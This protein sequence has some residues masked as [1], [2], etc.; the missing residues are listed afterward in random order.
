[1]SVTSRI[2][3]DQAICADFDAE[4]ASPRAVMV[5]WP[6]LIFDPPDDQAFITINI[7]CDSAEQIELGPDGRHR[8]VGVLFAN[9]FCPVGRGEAEARDIAEAIGDR[10][11]S[12]T[13]GGIV[14][15]SPTVGAGI[16]D[17]GYL[18]ITVQCPF[19]ADLVR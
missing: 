11:R 4:V 14:F 6:N 19:I 8:F 15:R 18:R 7:V 5:A 13:R 16:R 17:R 1:M 12:A 3:I 9:V 2:E 10:Y